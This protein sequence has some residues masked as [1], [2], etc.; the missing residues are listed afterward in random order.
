MINSQHLAPANSLIN[1]NKGTHGLMLIM[2][3]LVASSFPVGAAITYALPPVVMMFLRFFLAALLFAPYVIAKNGWALPPLRALFGYAL[4]SI[5][6]VIFFW[7]MFEALRHTSAINT[8]ALYTTLPAMTALASYIINQ[9]TISKRRQLGLLIGTVGA[10]WIVF[11]GQISAL[12]NLQLNSGDLLFLVGC[13]SLSV[14]NPLM[15]KRYRG[16]RQELMT[17]WVILFGAVWLLVLALPSFSQIDW[18]NVPFKVYAG[19]SYLALFTTLITFFLLQ[20]GTLK[21]GPI[22]V[23]AYSYLTP[24]FV[25]LLTVLMGIEQL[26]WQ[27]LPGAGFILIAMLL[28]QNEPR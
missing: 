23:A 13:L 16:E 19:I 22:K 21:L 4:L 12:V 25:I 2:V 8:G 14:Y 7:C 11:R 3:A 26:D 28:I 1:T 24:L 18:S 27:T 15:K 17:F 6:L 20:I 5:P 10:L 9:Q